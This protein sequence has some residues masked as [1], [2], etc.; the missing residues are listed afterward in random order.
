MLAPSWQHMGPWALSRLR[1]WGSIPC[2]TE[3]VGR[4]L[5]AAGGGTANSVPYIPSLVGEAQCLSP[6]PSVSQD[7]A[8][9]WL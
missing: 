9:E 3:W 4:Y 5:Q 8:L 7:P 2:R 6:V 1:V